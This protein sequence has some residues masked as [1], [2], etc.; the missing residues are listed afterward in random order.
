MICQLKILAGPA[1]GKLLFLGA[2]QCIEVGRLAATD[3]PIP[4]DPLLSRRHLLFESTQ[5]GVRV[6]DLGSSNGT[7]LNDERVLVRAILDGDL[8]R[9]GSTI[10]RVSMM[11]SVDHTLQTICGTVGALETNND[12][13][14]VV[15]R[16]FLHSSQQSPLPDFLESYFMR[17]PGEC[18]CTL[19]RSWESE[20]GEWSDLVRLISKRRQALLVVNLA[21]L[22]S[23]SSEF[24]QKSPFITLSLPMSPS[25]RACFVRE[26]D[27]VWKMT[28]RCTQSDSLICIFGHKIPS[29][30][31][32]RDYSDSLSFPSLFGKRI[33]NSDRELLNFLKKYELSVLFEASKSGP[34]CLLE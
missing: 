24:F 2:N 19:K 25:L 17:V 28:Q 31:L 6:R 4:S 3:F 34:I 10:I 32:F 8:I 20:F 15:A 11:T 13:P 23:E 27:E 18:F 7:F 22:D 16:T 5:G 29:I 26:T 12:E 1:A 21:E 9:A 33:A 30:D 14:T